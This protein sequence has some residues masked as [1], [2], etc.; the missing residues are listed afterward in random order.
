MNKNFLADEQRW[1]AWM[2]C[3]QRGDLAD[4]AQ[5]LRELGVVIETYIRVRFGTIDA[6]E[7]CVQECLMA[8]HAARHTYDPRRLFRPWLFT[9]VRHKTIDQLRQRQTWLSALQALA[10]LETPAS[11][12]E[13]NLRMLDGV[14]IL[15]RLS[16]DHR[17]MITLAKYGGYTTAEAATWLGISESAAKARLQRALVAIGK[18]L[19]SEGLP[20]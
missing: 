15:E 1:A 9:I 17:E 14:R 5:L 19:D 12:P 6:L 2:A 4:Y 8:V 3:A 11:D 20:V 13:R 7:D 16:P 18:V 10:T